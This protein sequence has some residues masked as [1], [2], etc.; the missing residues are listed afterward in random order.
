MT[1]SY[2]V[3]WFKH[4][5][6]ALDE[7]LNVL[8]QTSSYPHDLLRHVIQTPGTVEKQTALITRRG[9]PVAIAG[10]RRLSRLVW[11]PVNRWLLPGPVFT[12]K[13]ETPISALD[14]LSLEIPIAWWRMAD[15]PPS[16]PSIRA[17]ETLP[18][19]IML[20]TDNHE[21]FWRET[22]YLKTIKNTRNRCKNFTF[23]IDRPGVADWVIQN[24]ST[25]W[26]TE[27][28]ADPSLV[29][30]QAIAAFLEPRGLHHTIA[31]FDNG[32]LIGGSTNLVD[33][34]CLVA[35][36]LYFE[37][38]YRRYNAG[39]RLIDLAFA[40]SLE[41]GLTAFDL[42]GRSEYK[43]KW[44]PERGTRSSFVYSPSVVY[45]TRQTA[46][47]A[48]KIYGATRHLLSHAVPRQNLSTG[49][50]AHQGAQTSGNDGQP[51]SQK[52]VDLP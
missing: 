13:E 34:G 33:R 42:G 48:H 37:P 50:R 30:R 17:L 12:A 25:K 29:D 2:N 15:P 1:E 38:E 5:H 28:G 31:L 51:R 36:V 10:L 19:Y 16:S 26:R 18:T 27:P 41:R 20:N 11:E 7:A 14:S 52:E 43:K 32:K 9:V 4:W 39:I 44:A 21:E 6:P 23:E 3:R 8:P 49:D 46:A 24:W 45:R 35:G 22:D 40:L 47:L